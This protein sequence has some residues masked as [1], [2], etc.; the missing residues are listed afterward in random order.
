MPCLRTRACCV[1]VSAC[2]CA[3][4]ARGRRSG[5]RPIRGA[6]RAR[7]W[8][9]RRRRLSS[10]RWPIPKAGRGRRPGRRVWRGCA[11]RVVDGVLPRRL[12]VRFEVSRVLLVLEPG[13]GAPDGDERGEKGDPERPAEGAGPGEEALT[14]GLADR[15]GVGGDDQEACGQRVVGTGRG[16][17]ERKGR[18]SSALTSIDLGA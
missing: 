7:T 5:K 12:V 9:G 15:L 4:S 18:V 2:T 1:A 3:P 8:A 6:Q 10:R 11:P 17:A 16:V 13:H 14:G